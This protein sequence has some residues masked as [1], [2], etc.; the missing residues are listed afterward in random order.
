M[1]SSEQ[2]NEIFSALSKAQSE[3][4]GAIK[5]SSNPFFKSNYADLASV[6]GVLQ[7][8]LA[9]NGLCVVQTT[10]EHPDGVLLETTLGHTSGQWISSKLF[11]RPVKNDPQSV[12]SCLTY[13]RRYSL[14][15]L[16]GV[17]AIDDDG[18][19]ASHYEAPKAKGYE[20]REEAHNAARAAVVIKP[21]QPAPVEDDVA[22]DM[23]DAQP[24]G[25]SDYGNTTISGTKLKVFHDKVK[26]YGWSPAA[27]KL[28]LASKGVSSSTAM[29][30]ANFDAIVADLGNDKV[31]HKYEMETTK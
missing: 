16:C 11:M 19:A 31:K 21:V 23:F 2:K 30:N 17:I 27:A 18:N 6:W 22:L 14:A 3:L 9:K 29:T 10:E 13:A 1:N 20:K 7:L 12:G 4:Q 25:V 15:A 5:D 24:S 26:S 28:L 8:P